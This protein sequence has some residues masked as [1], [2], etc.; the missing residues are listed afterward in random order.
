MIYIHYFPT[1]GGCNELKGE[2]L[3]KQHFGIII[4]LKCY[5]N[6]FDF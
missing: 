2:E 6:Q 4:M 3:K 1:Q 5:Q